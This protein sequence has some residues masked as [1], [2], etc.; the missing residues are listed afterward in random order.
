MNE[1]QI[2][3]LFNTSDEAADASGP[4]IRPNPI[5]L[6]LKMPVIIASFFCAR[7]YMY[8]ILNPPSIFNEPMGPNGILRRSVT[9][10]P[11]HLSQ[12]AKFEHM[13]TYMLYF[14]RY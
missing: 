14:P 12:F 8:I 6:I 13:T 2:G 7:V 3:E 10:L 11:R 4:D 1:H 9:A 5:Y